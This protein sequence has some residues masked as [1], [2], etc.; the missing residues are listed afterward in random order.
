MVSQPTDTDAEALVRRSVLFRVARQLFVSIDAAADRSTL[1]PA[2]TRHVSAATAGRVLIVASLVH[3][4]LV[5]A[6]PLAQAPLGRYSL[7]LAGLIAGVTLE[8]L[9]RSST[10]GARAPEAP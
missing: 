6:I 10:L 1:L 9:S 7:A 5:T 8:L 2:L 3:A 4:A